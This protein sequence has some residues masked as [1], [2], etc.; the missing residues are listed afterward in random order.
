MSLDGNALYRCFPA[1][2][3][4]LGCRWLT[5]TP[6]FEDVILNAVALEPPAS[7]IKTGDIDPK[8]L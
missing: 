4:R 1:R 2:H 3:R 6:S 8:S 7:S 5:A